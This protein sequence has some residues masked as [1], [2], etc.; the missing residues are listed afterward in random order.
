M[1]QL[2]NNENDRYHI[3][4]KATI[5][6]EKIVFYNQ[7]IRKKT[8]E[9][10][11]ADELK[12]KQK[13]DIKNL[14]S[15]TK[16]FLAS[17]GAIDNKLPA[18]N[19]HN[20]EISIKASQRIKEK[21]SWLYSLA[22]NKTVT[23][24]NG[25]VL[26]CFKMNFITLTLP[27]KQAHST[28][29]INKECLNQFITECSQQFGLKNYVWRLEFQKNGNAHYHIATDTY[30]EFWRCRKIWNRIINKLGYVDAYAQ[31]FSKYTFAEYYK[32]F[33]KQGEEDFNTLK[34]RFSA[35][36]STKWSEPNTVDCRNV[37]NAKNI[38]F[39][40]SKY[41]TKKSD[42]KL[43]SIVSER[44]NTETN[45]RLWFCSR[46]LSK[47]SKIEV[48][49]EQ[50]DTTIDGVLDTLT[51]KKEFIFDY[52]TVVY[53]SL[54]EQVTTFKQNYWLLLNNYAKSTGYYS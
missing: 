46:S 8:I 49:L 16:I 28:D 4:P 21:V 32:E 20:Y 22:K 39:Y 42:A 15:K 40:I 45:L 47:L 3:L 18:S 25:K 26:H 24:H 13:K 27:S 44:D 34:G 54:K 14:D 31:K 1:A 38:S 19:K 37:T 9:E 12:N 7:F 23:T 35:G 29:V 17:I 6:P 11:K 53:F 50:I 41:I 43:N 48:F 33:H 10:I 36:V 52:C 5:R 30:I 2:I 51:N